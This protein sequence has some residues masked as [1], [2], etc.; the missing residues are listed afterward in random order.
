MEF[1]GGNHSHVAVPELVE[2]IVYLSQKGLSTLMV[3]ED[4]KCFMVHLGFVVHVISS[5]SSD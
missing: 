5:K 1:Y 4:L 2:K 3:F